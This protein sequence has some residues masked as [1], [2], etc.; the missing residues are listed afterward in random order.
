MEQQPKLNPKFPYRMEKVR[1]YLLFMLFEQII[2]ENE[3]DELI[4]RIPEGY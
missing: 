3:F 4:S 1:W 2:S